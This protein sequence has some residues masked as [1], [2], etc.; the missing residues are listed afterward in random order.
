MVA[1]TSRSRYQPG[2]AI[3]RSDR[4]A[5]HLGHPGRDD[6]ENAGRSGTGALTRGEAPSGPLGLT[7]APNGDLIAV[8]GSKG[9]AI[10]IAPPMAATRRP[11]PWFRTEP[12][13]LLGGTAPAGGQ[14]LLLVND[15]TSAPGLCS[16]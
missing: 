10:E 14:G 15:G 2:V 12:V 8:N 13:D 7:V 1:V 11:W 3:A 5:Q 6:Q 4:A 16:A 9:K